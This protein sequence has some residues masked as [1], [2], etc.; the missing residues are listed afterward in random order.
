[1]DLRKY[2]V[3]LVAYKWLQYVLRSIWQTRQKQLEA[4]AHRLDRGR[5]TAR[6]E[7]SECCANLSSRSQTMQTSCPFN[8]P[9]GNTFDQGRVIAQAVSRR[10][11]TAAARVRSQVRPCGIFGGQ[12]GTGAG[13]FRVLRFPLPILI[14]PTTPHS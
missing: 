12:S 10:F 3:N 14:P 2:L 9:K 8:E 6:N 4:S 5:H 1:M 13:F 7:V 11:A